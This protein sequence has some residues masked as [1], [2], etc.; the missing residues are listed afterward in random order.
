MSLESSTLTVTPFNMLPV[1]RKKHL[2]GQTATPEEIKKEQEEI[3]SKIVRRRN[4]E[5]ERD[6]AAMALVGFIINLRVT[7]LIRAHQVRNLG[8]DTMVNAFACNFK[9]GDAVNKD[10][11]EANFLNT[12][13]YQRLS[14]QTVKDDLKDRPIIILRT[15][16]KQ[17]DY[18][19]AL[20][21]FKSRIGLS[22]SE[23]LVVLSN[24]SMCV[25]SGGFH[26]TCWP[27]DSF[28]HCRSPF[29][30]TGQFLA[31]ITDGFRATAEEEIK[32]RKF[33]FVLF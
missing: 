10:V 21:K 33:G 11:I 26:M 29:P 25:G 17:A 4:D 1:E 14:V 32:V 18:L 3:R 9:V 12:R 23:N 2:E 6:E 13:I 15:E 30:T 22:G 16:L 7:F 31:K 28:T 19:G 8:S 5:L 27:I 24:V 20:D